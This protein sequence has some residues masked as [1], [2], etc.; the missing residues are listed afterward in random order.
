MYNYMMTTQLRISQVLLYILLMSMIKIKL[1]LGKRDN[2]TIKIHINHRPLRTDTNKE[3]I[4]NDDHRHEC[5]S[6][7]RH[8]AMHVVNMDI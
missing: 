5:R 7:R 3:R 6:L 2:T 1:L 8:S 4:H